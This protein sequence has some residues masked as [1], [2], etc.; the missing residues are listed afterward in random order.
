MT[1]L[2]TN[3]ICTYQMYCYCYLLKFNKGINISVSHLFGSMKCK[4]DQNLSCPPPPLPLQTLSLCMCASGCLSGDRWVDLG[5]ATS[6][7][8]YPANKNPTKTQLCHIHLARSK[9][10]LIP[11][12]RP[13]SHPPQPCLSKLKLLS[14]IYYEIKGSILRHWTCWP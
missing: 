6:D 9:Y 2:C 5:G 10:L 7:A 11:S 14:Q 1:K 8:F 3:H 13:Q 12:A 4:T